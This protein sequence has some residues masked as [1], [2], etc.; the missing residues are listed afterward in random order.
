[1]AGRLCLSCDRRESVPRARYFMS[2]IGAPFVFNLPKMQRKRLA[3]QTTGLVR[4]RPRWEGRWDRWCATRTKGW[5]GTWCVLGRAVR[6]G[7]EGRRG[8]GQC[9]S[10]E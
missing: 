3:T 2:V 1:M 8:G 10:E 4:P 6:E 9:L 7:A 5:Q